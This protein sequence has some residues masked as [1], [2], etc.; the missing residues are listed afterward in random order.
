MLSLENVH[1]VFQPGRSLGLELAA[2]F[3]RL[4]GRETEPHGV[5]AVRGVSLELRPGEILGLVGESGS[6]KSTLGR[7][8][9]GLYQPD[10]GRAL[11][12]GLDLAALDRG[13][14]K[15]F[16]RRVLRRYSAL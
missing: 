15:K 8:M 4:T 16:R 7:I 13:G 9:A 14:R 3:G 2:W 11:F 10:E 12:D 6:G 5:R 1:K